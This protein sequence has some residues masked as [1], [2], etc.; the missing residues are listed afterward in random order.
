MVTITNF[1]EVGRKDGSS[2]ISSE[3][4]C[5]AELIQSQTQDNGMLL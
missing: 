3:L 4:T 5:S 1:Y 2:F